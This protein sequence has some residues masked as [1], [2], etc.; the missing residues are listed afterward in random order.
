MCIFFFLLCTT[1]LSFL[2]FFS[3]LKDYINTI[4]KLTISTKQKCVPL[5]SQTPI[6]KKAITVF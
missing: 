2:V 3:R 5:I 6:L 4:Q 1:Q